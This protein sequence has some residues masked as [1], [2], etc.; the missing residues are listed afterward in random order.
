MNSDHSDN[1]DNK[2]TLE[3]SIYSLKTRIFNKSKSG[4]S[5]K[6]LNRRK[7]KLDLMIKEEDS[8]F[9]EEA[10]KNRDV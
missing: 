10:I 3:Q 2:Y 5:Y 8:Y 1:N 4:L 7:T 6:I 9:S